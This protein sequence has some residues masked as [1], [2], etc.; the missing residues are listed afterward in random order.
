[1]KIQIRSKDDQV[2]ET[3]PFDI[4]V[5][6]RA[7]EACYVKDIILVTEEDAIVKTVN[8]NRELREGYAFVIMFPE[9]GDSN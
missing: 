2:L 4:K 8:I 3:L 9:Q 1:M 6:W 7:K 5:E